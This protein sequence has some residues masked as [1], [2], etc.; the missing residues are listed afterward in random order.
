MKRRYRVAG[1]LAAATLILAA[2]GDDDDDDAVSGDTGGTS[3]GTGATTAGTGETDDT[4]DLS[5]GGDVS[6]EVVTHGQASDPFWSVFKKG[7]D[8]AAA[9]MGVSANY[10]APD[11]FDMVEMAQ[12]ID[13]A[14]AKGPDALVVSVPDAAALTD[15]LTAATDA[16]IALITVNSGSDVYQELGAITHIGQDEFI[17]GQAAGARLAEAG[18]TNVICINQEV[19]NA[20]LDARCAGAQE[21]IE[22]AGGTLE[23]VQVDLND[24][25]GAQNTIASTLQA[26]ADVNG[27]L[28]LGPTGSAP[29]LA[30]LQELGKAGEIQLATFDLSPEVLD[31][32][33]A[34]DM[35][36]AVDQQQYLQGYLP[37]VFLTLYANNLNTVGGGQP[38]LTGPGFVVADNAAEIKDLAAAGTR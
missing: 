35:L 20:G 28:A 19:G 17:A 14:V 38:V 18:A 2:C 1:I 24:A 22:A 31:A 10:S 29:T 6:I 13:A 16:G 15:S 3:A 9:Q 23:V 21:S 25:A 26:N 33:E 5:Q 11:T 4:V 27:V 12:L 32:I 7:V 36:F 37:I 34:G 30:A 8:D